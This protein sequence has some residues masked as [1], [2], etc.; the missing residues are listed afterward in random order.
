MKSY[1][2]IV[3][4]ISTLPQMGRSQGLIDTLQI[5]QLNTLE[6]ITEIYDWPH[7]RYELDHFVFV[8]KTKKWD[9][10]VQYNEGESIST[11][12]RELLGRAMAGDTLIIK[13]VYALNSES[14]ESGQVKLPEKRIL[15]K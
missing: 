12:S 2:V 15:L 13:E 10:Q 8:L 1:I 6:K 4:I 7:S 9:P 11:E 3:F 14:P 5:G